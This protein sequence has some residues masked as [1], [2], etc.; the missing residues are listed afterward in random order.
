MLYGKRHG[1]FFIDCGLIRSACLVSLLV[2]AGYL[3]LIEGSRSSIRILIL[4]LLVFILTTLVGA[5][6]SS[7]VKFN[8]VQSYLARSAAYPE[9]WFSRGAIFDGKVYWACF[10]IQSCQ[11]SRHSASKCL[12]RRFTSGL[13]PNI[14]VYD[15]S[16]ISLKTYRCFILWGRKW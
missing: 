3:V 7:Y 12:C 1:G 5:M 11:R 13:L 16:L 6:P 8:Q 15:W 4:G 9:D 14:D 2:W 10:E